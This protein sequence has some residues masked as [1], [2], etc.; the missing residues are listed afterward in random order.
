MGNISVV[1]NPFLPS[2]GRRI[3]PIIEGRTIESLLEEYLDTDMSVLV[4]INGNVCSDYSY[5]IKE[6]DHITLMAKVQG[7]DGGKDALRIVAFIAVT[8][9]SAGF[10]SGYFA[11]ILGGGNFGA[12]LSATAVSVGGGLLINAILPPALPEIG[13]FE[14]KQDSNTYGWGQTT[15]QVDEGL[16]ASVLYGQHKI[17]PQVIGRYRNFA[18]NQDYINLLF[19]ISEGELSSITDIKINDIDIADLSNQTP[20]TRL[21]TLSQTAIPQFLDTITEKVVNFELE[22]VDDEIV[23]QTDGNA[24]EKLAVG[25]VIPNGLFRFA[26]GQYLELST[27]FTLQYRAVGSGTWLDW[28]NLDDGTIDSWNVGL[29]STAGKTRTIQKR[30]TTTVD[31]PRKRTVAS[32]VEVDETD[33]FDDSAYTVYGNSPDT[34]RFIFEH[35]TDL[36]PDQ[37][38][39]RVVRKQKFSTASGSSARSNALFV[40]HI[41]EK[42]KDDFTYPNRALLGLTAVAQEKVYGGQPVITCVAERSTINTYSG[43][44]GVGSPVA[45][46]G[47][48]PAWAC[49]D[50]L[51]H[52]M[53]GAGLHPDQIVLQDFIDWDAFCTS[54]NLEANIYI[55][56]S[57]SMFDALKQIGLLGYG[58]VVQ[59]GTKFGALWDEASSMVHMFTMG[60][61]I[62]N[63]LRMGYIEKEN[64]ANT[65]DVTYY[66]STLDWDRKVLT[67]KL[68][69]TDAEEFERK[70]A[71]NLVGCTSRQQA[72]DYAR[73]VLRGNQYLVRTVQFT[74]DIDAV[75]VQV[76][77][78][79]GLSHDVPLYGESGR[80]SSST[81]TTITLDREVSMETGKTYQITVRDSDTDVLETQNILNSGTG[82]YSTLTIDAGGSWTVNPSKNDI[83]AFGETD[84]QVKKFR[85]TSVEKSQ[86]LQV[87]ISGLEYRE[88]I[89]VNDPSALPDYEQEANAPQLAGLRVDDRYKISTDGTTVGS[90]SITWR[91]YDLY[92]DVSVSEKD[93]G[94]TRPEWNGTTNQ[95]SFEVKN[96]EI[97]KT[98][99][100]RVESATKQILE[101]DYTPSVDGPEIPINLVGSQVD[102]FVLLDWEEPNSDVPIARYE[103]R[104]GDDFIT[105]EVIGNADKTFTSFYETVGGTYTYWVN[106]ISENG[107]I[108]DADTVTLTVDS[109]ADFEP[110]ATPLKPDGTGTSTNFIFDN[111]YLIGP[112]SSTETW[113]EFWDEVYPPSASGKTWQDF[114]DDG[115]EW[116]YDPASGEPTQ[117]TYEEV[118]DLGAVIGEASLSLTLNKQLLTSSN[119]IP[120]VTSEISYSEDGISYTSGGNSLSVRAEDFRYIKLNLT[121]DSDGT[122]IVSLCPEIK[123][124][125]KK[126][127]QVGEGTVVVANDGLVVNLE[128]FYD[129]YS[130]Q[131]TPKG[132]SFRSPVYDFNDVPNPSDFTVYLYDENAV[133]QTGI[134]TYT[135]TGI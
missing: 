83:Y 70:T 122:Q 56:Q 44:W 134:F 81:A 57:A 98:Y 61:I 8:V 130:I 71:I 118:F 114:I 18:G 89:Y 41:Q 19:H 129:V 109:P 85:C 120:V 36:T 24:V 25:I 10:A 30:V 16:T 111:P 128:G 46:N 80:V 22:E 88:E 131:V 97:Y 31:A 132:T 48:S 38:E 63:S 29:A 12:I 62:E 2:D 99:T 107:I 15:N 73:F 79:F 115:F 117:A 135:V 101:L 35:D 5:E 51:T 105:A 76:G 78:V 66:D 87:T 92:W 110:L 72:I 67:Q 47:N 106:A 112:I 127:T 103:I 86:D 94:V 102:N 82:T 37:Y 123:V 27:R 104:K 45:R 64:R 53:Y 59:R 55:D 11:P 58:S 9:V 50:M 116:L 113:E 84:S 26:E 108:G 4:T 96:I 133:R 60:N 43:D 126:K 119:S 69:E 21:G 121:V 14:N 1:K 3:I 125:A 90:L 17:T 95:T 42:I 23:I 28:S 77:D 13:S 6:N 32:F 65:I 124:E 91:G 33:V 74:C 100:V 20:A 68:D 34:L 40:S 54:N 7:G 39:I 52:P 49:Y 75:P 93:T